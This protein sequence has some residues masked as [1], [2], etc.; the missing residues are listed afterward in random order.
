MDIDS[1]VSNLMK[2]ERIPL[3]KLNQ[4]KQ[5]WQWKQEDYRTINTTL[6]TLRDLAF[7]AKLQGTYM[8]K[9]ASSSNEAAAIVTAGS[10]ATDGFY[11]LEIQKMAKGIQ[12]SSSGGLPEETKTV[13]GN[14]QT[15]S[16]AGQFSAANG[17][18]P[19][20]ADVSGTI[21]V[22]I[23]GNA[24]NV[25]GT[26]KQLTITLDSVNNN[27][28]NLAT[29]INSANLGIKANY[30]AT[31]NRFTIVSSSTGSDQHFKVVSDAEIGTGSGK[32]FLKDYLKLGVSQG[33]DY[34]G[35]NAE[36]KLS[37]SQYSTPSNTATVMGMTIALK[38]APTDPA[39]P[40]IMDLNVF[41]DTNTIYSS[42]K[43]FV[44]KYN[45]VVEKINTKLQEKRNRDYKPLTDDQKNDMNDKQIEQ[46]EEKAR[47]GLLNFDFLLTS[48][49]DKL[50][51]AASS[52]VSGL[53]QYNSLASVG[54][55]T[56]KYNYSGQLEIDDDRLKEALSNNPD[57]VMKL[58]TNSS[59]IANEKGIATRAYDEVSNG[60]DLISSE[61]G[62]S[63][64]FSLL[65]KSFIG[66]KLTSI[67][68]R[69]RNLNDQLTHKE[70]RY[71]RQFTAME[72]AINQMNTQSSWLAQQLGMSTQQK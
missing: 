55:T 5:S 62:S 17:L 30:D 2:A 71:Y 72:K 53:T 43:S 66:N 34:S 9:K 11:T 15:Q 45:E 46:W 64:S 35:Q 58:F 23:E 8:A 56:K 6:S 41:Q 65:D 69:I 16:L 13:A 19:S 40:I 29:Q 68:E 24:K 50:R 12:I 39:A 21:I 67:D 33:V 57:A 7:T 14:T 51:T 49:G 31:Y 38:Q 3:E 70:E 59:G 44:D 20:L 54:I 61:A 47:S 32:Y 10:S 37:G 52:T 18:D 26:Y 48:I 60:M 28:N 42:I 63:S 22:T 1:I 27:I 4:E 36:F 25:D